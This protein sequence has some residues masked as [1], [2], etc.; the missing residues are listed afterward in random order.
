MAE[1][2]QSVS[3]PDTKP[4]QLQANSLIADIEKLVVND[5]ESHAQA[6]K[7][8]SEA[9]LIDKSIEEKFKE[10]TS[11]ANKIHKFLTGLAATLRSPIVNARSLAKRK[12]DI[13]ADAERRR[14]EEEAKAKAQEAFK[15]EQNRKINEALIAE[16]LGDKE[17]ATAILDEEISTPYLPATPDIAKV[18]G[19]SER[20]GYYAVVLDLYKL[21]KYVAE[22]PDEIALLGE[23]ANEQVNGEVKRVLKSGQVA[24]NQRARS[25]RREGEIVPGV[26]GVKKTSMSQRRK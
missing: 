4:L 9:D 22:K 11:A 16:E 10:P 21:V 2:L 1:Q 3:V 24:L 23:V 12:A 20:E 8:W 26:I 19:I 14:A 15:A 6:L 13:W 7:L 5:K 25:M 18:D 17:G